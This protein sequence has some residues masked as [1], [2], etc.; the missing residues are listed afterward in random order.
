ML[1]YVLIFFAKLV[2][3][4]LA[5]VRN[6]L[7]NR[8][9]KLKGALIGFFEVMIWVLVVNQVLAGL[10][11]DP[12]KLIV[13]CLAFACGNYLGVIIENKLAIGMACIQVV[14]K[15]E[16]KEALSE[17]LRS[18]DFGVTIVKGEGKN[19]PVDVLMIYLKRKRSKEAIE[20][21]HEFSPKSLITI[22]DIRHLRNGYIKK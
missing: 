11:E 13:Y 6:V 18:R 19:G 5:T 12:L 15:E 22:N 1:I 2:E 4:S 14:V 21:I 17:A 9:E 3:V 10:S 20:L 16:R 8:G 7:I